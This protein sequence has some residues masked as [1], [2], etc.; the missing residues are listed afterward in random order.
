MG[1]VWWVHWAKP[2]GDQTR[3][4]KQDIWGEPAVPGLTVTIC[5]ERYIARGGTAEGRQ[6]S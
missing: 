2:K 5:C 3:Q 6:V 1:K 4:L